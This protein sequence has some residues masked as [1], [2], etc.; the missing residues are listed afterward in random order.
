MV[1]YTDIIYDSSDARLKLY[2]RDYGGAGMP[3][4]CMHGLTRNSADFEWIATHLSGLGYRVIAV[5]QRG[6]GKSA[7][8]PEPVYYTPAVYCGDMLKLLGQ[9]GITRSVLIGT[10]MGGLMAMIM[11]VMAPQAVI[12]MVINDIGPEIDKT[13]LDRIASYTGKGKPV[14]TWADA[15]E[16]AKET[17]GIAFPDYHDNDWLDFARRTYAMNADGQLAPAYDPAI[18][19]AFATPQPT[20]A[21]PDLWGLWDKLEGL[22]ILSIRGGISDLLSADTVTK[23]GERHAGMTAV[24]VRNRGHA[25]MLDESEAVIAIEA[26]LIEMEGRR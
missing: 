14:A 7:W 21:P 20:V 4:L 8:D 3:V 13:G 18:S 9:L 22:P 6:R 12:G 23:M 25:P 11:G 19:N 5:D 1:G 10:S 2:A 17:N 24:T 26:F 15:A 16:R